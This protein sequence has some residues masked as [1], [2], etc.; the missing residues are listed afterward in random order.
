MSNKTQTLEQLKAAFAKAESTKDYENLPNNYYRFWDM[1]E[2]ERCVVRF[3]PDGNENNPF[4]FLVQK[5]M[6][7]LEINGEKKSV[8]CLSMYEDDCP[9]CKVSQEFYK[10]KD[11]VN[12]KK[13]WK[14]KQYITQ[15]L[16]IEDPLPVDEKT[17]ENHEGK[18]R[19]IALGFQLYKIINEAFK[20]DEVLDSIPYNYEDGYDF[21]IKKTKQGKYDA[22]NVGSM[23]AR[24][25]RPLTD[26][27]M[28]VVNENLI[29]LS[30]LLPKHPSQEKV[31]G[32]LEAAMTGGEYKDASKSTDDE[33]E[34]T[35]PTPR[36]AATDD[37]PEPAP[38]EV[39]E[40]KEPKN[41][42]SDDAQ[43]DVEDILLQIKARRNAASKQAS[44]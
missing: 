7:V 11:E 4:G 2:N 32:M 10:V 38:K 35:P 42:P 22:Y 29:D 37:A 18:L 9:V 36:S 19:F 20:S 13:Y 14:K 16:I 30:T 17:G 26:D 6:H 27:E 31:D 1:K 12:G 44:K 24:K 8:P 34:I 40:P 33:G 25:Q 15:A 23:F 43:S 39:K 28:A 21:I 41:K 5:V 3:L